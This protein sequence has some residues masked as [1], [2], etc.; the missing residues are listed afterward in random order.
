[1]RHGLAILMTAAGLLCA[2]PGLA[3]PKPVAHAAPKLAPGWGAWGGMAGSEWAAEDGSAIYVYRWKIPGEILLV[4]VTLASAKRTTTIALDETGEGLTLTPG[5]AAGGGPVAIWSLTNPRPGV[6]VQED[7]RHQERVVYHFTPDEIVVDQTDLKDGVW[8]AAYH[9]TR[10]RLARGEATKSIAAFQSRHDEAV[11]QQAKAASDYAAQWGDLLKLVGKRWTVPFGRK[12][13]NAEIYWRPG[14]EGKVMSFYSTDD[15]G[16]GGRSDFTL[17]PAGGLLLTMTVTPN[18]APIRGTVQPDGSIMTVTPY[19]GKIYAGRQRLLDADH[20]ENQAGMLVNGVFTPTGKPT[21]ATYAGPS[22]VNARVAQETANRQ[23]SSDAKAAF[24]GGA[25][26]ALGQV[27]AAATDPNYNPMGGSGY[28][29]GGG[30]DL[31]PSTPQMWGGQAGGGGASTGLT[32][33]SPPPQS[34]PSPQSSPSQNT[35]PQQLLPDPNSKPKIKRDDCYLTP[36][37]PAYRP[38][39]HHGTACPG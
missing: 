32:V 22:D 5:P 33:A 3:A 4:E 18:E 21:V 30:P 31:T 26:N 34:A 12:F 1:M 35:Y 13:I 2:Q 25:L 14:Q 38:E 17:D 39:G 16:L 28:A 36:D 7:G 37:D 29:S 11:A 15:K 10:H 9:E 8:Q 20:Y 19:G 6:S 23:A 27:A 24:W